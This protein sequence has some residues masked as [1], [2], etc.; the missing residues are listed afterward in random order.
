MRTGQRRVPNPST[1]P[2]LNN[3]SRRFLGRSVAAVVLL[4]AV[5]WL[6]ASK[7][8]VIHSIVSPN[9]TNLNH[10][11][12]EKSPYLLQ[13]ADN[14]VDWYPW[15]DEAFEKARREDKPI[16]LSIGY[17]TCHWC[18]VMERESFED[19]EVARL[20]NDTF[21]C[22]KVDRE[23]RPDVD[24]IYMRVCQIMTGSGGWPLTIIMTPDKVPFFAGTYIPK[25]ARFGQPGLIEL[26]SQVRELWKTDREAI[27]TSAEKIA[28]LLRQASQPKPGTERLDETTLQQGYAVLR[29]SYD[30]RFG[31]FGQAPKFPSPH[32]FFFLLRYALRTGSVEALDMVLNTLRHMRRGGI[33]DQIGFGFHRYSTDRQ[34]LVPHFEKMLYDQG[35]MLMAYVEAYQITGDGWYREVG[36]EIITYLLRDLRDP[37]GG[38]YSSEDA[39][40]EGEEGKFYLWTWDELRALLTDEELALAAELFGVRSEGNFVDPL[41]GQRT[42]Q[43]VLHLAK[44]PTG[45]AREHSLTAEQLKSRAAGILE[46]LRA[47]RNKRV[48]PARDDKIL[49]D[50]NGLTIAA[51][52]KAGRAFGSGTALQAAKQAADFILRQLLTRQGKL[53]H[54]YRDGDAAINAFLDDYAF[55]VFGLTEL[56]MSTFEP[57]Y[58]LR[59]VEL[60]ETTIEE[61]Q[62]EQTG[63]F[64]LS[65]RGAETPLMRPHDFYDGAIPCGAAVITYDLLRLARLTGRVEFE[66]A[67]DRSFRAA[68]TEIAGAPAAHT[69]WLSALDFVLGPSHEVVIVSGSGPDDYNR[70]T[71]PLGRSFLPN[72]VVLL[73]RANDR[74]L[75]KVAPFVRGYPVTAGQTLAYV[76]QNFSCQ[77]PVG[78]PQAMLRAVLPDPEN[79]LLKRY[80]ADK[81]GPGKAPVTSPD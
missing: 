48:R 77:A 51:L 71:G 66:Q 12:H 23:E 16:F 72:A 13:H 18:H 42:G 14:P 27:L 30:S 79:C 17:S 75:E 3:H 25:R 8:E 26:V 74:V 36:E 63:L 32:N 50:W 34:W 4:T 64:Y 31:G 56:Y 49:T 28:S 15:G 45:L 60:A 1:S 10:L 52:A 68:S 9:P 76:C 37:E 80:Q 6:L 24:Q 65:S 46:K 47:S 58:L 55:L 22:I 70:F 40:S 44:D 35:L 21:V 59:A 53:L 19:Q 61:F 33:Y 57:Q 38:F 69:F 73:K 41:T 78:N 2:T 81:P 54:R 5:T 67:A 39:D 43:N 62:D 29:R 7:P 20:L 11:A